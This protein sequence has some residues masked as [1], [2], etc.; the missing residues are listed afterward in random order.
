MDH[1][2]TYNIVR[3]VSGPLQQDKYPFVTQMGN[4]AFTHLLIPSTTVPTKRFIRGEK[5]EIGTIVAALLLFTAGMVLVMGIAV[6]TGWHAAPFAWLCVLC[7]AA[8][9]AAGALLVR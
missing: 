5:M 1:A 7:G 6:G 2:L 3:F 9:A 8:I 4:T